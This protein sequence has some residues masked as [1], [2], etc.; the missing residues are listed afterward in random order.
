MNVW[1]VRSAM[2]ANRLHA[3]KPAGVA[4]AVLMALPSSANAQAAPSMF[5]VQEIV[6]QYAHFT[7]PKDADACGL[8]R[9]DLAA[10]LNKSLQ[11]DSIPATAASEA[12]PQML[13][14]ARIELVPEIA[15]VNSQSLDCTS[16]ISLTAQSQG[17][18]HIPPIE[19][20]RSVTVV[21]WHQGLMVSSGQS[22]HAHA[23][24][25]ALERMAHAFAK[26]YRID[27]PPEIPKQ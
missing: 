4:L 6:V 15:P 1:N 9:E 10:V 22:T 21:Y 8:V 16:W 27:Q 14:V 13:G 19:T 3:L 7:N 12:K 24:E 20:P 11:I 26:Q 5:G 2:S 25:E 18:L 17:G 23:V